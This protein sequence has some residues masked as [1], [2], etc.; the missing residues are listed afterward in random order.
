MARVALCDVSGLLKDLIDKVSGES[1]DAWTQRTKIFLR[2][3]SV[4]AVPEGGICGLWSA[5]HLRVCND[6]CQYYMPPFH[7]GG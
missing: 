1:G 6:R 7:V 5:C 4:P 2:G 3:E